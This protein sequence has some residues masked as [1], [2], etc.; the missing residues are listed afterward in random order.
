M[1]I[2]Q[3]LINSSDD[4]S[5]D[6]GNRRVYKERSNFNVVGD[7]QFKEAFRLN[8]TQAEFVLLKIGDLLI[9]STNRSKRL[10]AEQKL[11]LCLSWLG[12]GSQYHA[13]AAMHG[14]SKSS[15]CRTIKQVTKAI[16][17]RMFQNT[18]CWPEDTNDIAVKFFRKGGFP[19]VCG[20][21]DG[22]MINI[23]APS[24]HE[25]Q[26]VNRHGK[27]SLNVMMISGPKY[28]VFAVNPNWPGSV[29]DSRVFRNSAVYRSFENGWRPFP[30]AVIL[31]DSAYGMKE[32]LM[33]PLNGNIENLR[34]RKFN[35]AHKATRR[36]VENTFGIMKERFPCLNHLRVSPRHAA[37][38]V[39]VCCVLHNV[40]CLVGR[41][42]N[43]FIVME[44]DIYE[45]NH[46]E[47]ANDLPDPIAAGDAAQ[48]RLQRLLQFFE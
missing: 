39:L 35:R 40:A 14:V 42:E 20:C 27:H 24:A 26:Y 32:W 11:L 28:E 23:D 1:D 43:D 34:E 47:P 13:T 25:E 3:E 21:V 45:D 10:N 7:F 38:I 18:V 6:E 41:D 29:H 2:I 12:K 4:S 19:S 46:V 33:A 30:D 16:V 48:A 31:G 17:R 36:M 8:R 9:P 44:E 37:E 15:V 5:E 22:T